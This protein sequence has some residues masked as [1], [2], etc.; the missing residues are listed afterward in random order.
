MPPIRP[1]AFIDFQIVGDR[2]GVQE[3]L[4]HVDSALSPVGLGLFLHGAIAPHL[5]RRAASR[6]KGEGDDAVGKWAPLE[7]STIL[8]REGYGFPPGPI[9]RRTGELENYIVNGGSDV[10][11]VPGMST[12]TYPDPNKAR[13]P[14]LS[15]KVQTAQMGKPGRSGKPT[16]RRPVLGMNETDLAAVMT[17]L[18]IHVQTWRGATP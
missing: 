15:K 5:K 18:A 3:M 10:K 7:E 16:P 6:F 1:T 14:H 11:S 9:N 2:T 13:G 8:I 4:N 12:L 17:K